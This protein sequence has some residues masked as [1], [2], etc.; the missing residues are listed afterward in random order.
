MTKTV[1]CPNHNEIH[2]PIHT[3][4]DKQLQSQNQNIQT[5]KLYNNIKIHNT[6]LD[7]FGM[8]KKKKR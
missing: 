7:R 5:D 8:K 2:S 4:P 3:P 6:Q 1:L